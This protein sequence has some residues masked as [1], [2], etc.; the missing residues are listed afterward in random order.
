MFCLWPAR[1][2]LVRLLV[3]LVVISASRPAAAAPSASTPSCKARWPPACSSASMSGRSHYQRV[4]FTRDH[5]FTL[6]AEVRADLAQLDP[7]SKT[8]VI[9]YQ[10]HKTFGLHAGQAAGRL[11][12]RRRAQGHREG[13]G[14][15]RAVPRH[16]PAAS[17]WKCSTPSRAITNQGTTARSDRRTVVTRLPL[18]ELRRSGRTSSNWQDGGRI[19][20]KTI[21]DAPENSLFFYGRERQRQAERPALSFNDFICWI[22]RR[23]RRIAADAAIWCCSIRAWSRSRSVCCIWKSN[24]RVSASPSFTPSCRRSSDL[25]WGLKGSRQALEKRGFEVK[26]IVLKKWSRF[27]PPTAAAATVDE[28][29]LER[30]ERTAEGLR[31]LIAQSGTASRLMP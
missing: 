30:L 31:Q 28:S 29:A 5:R 3:E 23:R 9:V 24:G 26:D 15:G 27:A 17:R 20:R 25:N 4:D 8:T 7:N 6:P 16:R 1:L 11:R 22:R 12:V 2:G 14:S 10:R 21:E 19:L 18:G 13:Q